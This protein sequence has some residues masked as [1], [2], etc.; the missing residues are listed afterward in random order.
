MTDGQRRIQNA[1]ARCVD[2][3]VTVETHESLASTNQ[4][5]KT[6]LAKLPPG[7]PFAPRVCV[8]RHQTAGIGRRGKVWLS[9]PDSITVSFARG[10]GCPAMG[11]SGLS[12]VTGIAVVSMLESLG[13]AH[14][15]LKWPNDV[16]LSG[17]K[18]AGILIDIPRASDS[19]TMTVTGIG[20]NLAEGEALAGVDQPFATL[21]SAGVALPDRETLTGLLV[22]TVLR[23]YTEFEH[24][25]WHPFDLRW[26]AL[27]QL[28]NKPV[29]LITSVSGG[30]SGGVSD[31]VSGSVSGEQAFYGVARGVSANGGLI[32]ESEGRLT[33]VYSGEVSVR[34]V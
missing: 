33:T 15:S 21:S 6:D 13:V 9:P 11:L 20:L 7:A 22:G 26:K 27:D 5:L 3:E 30:T 31:S 16:L 28:Y 17:R 14:L 1:I 23:D 12:L 19:L 8:A 2:T 4:H 24:H 34:T 25:G 10:F 29:K 18:L 32:I